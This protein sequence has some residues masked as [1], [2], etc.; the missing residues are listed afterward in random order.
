[1]K[2]YKNIAETSQNIVEPNDCY[3]DYQ[4]YNL[5][6]FNCGINVMVMSYFLE[7]MCRKSLK[8]Y[9][10]SETIMDGLHLIFKVKREVSFFREVI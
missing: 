7:M 1:M 2:L 4:Q 8:K 5:H 6:S 3:N 9:C 10:G